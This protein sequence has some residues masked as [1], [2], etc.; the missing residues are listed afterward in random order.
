MSYVL[1]VVLFILSFYLWAGIV[2]LAQAWAG[3]GLMNE[4]G[5]RNSAVILTGSLAIIVA[6][7]SA[8]LAL[9]A[10]PKAAS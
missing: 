8:V 1:S 7:V 4:I 2:F 9:R 10:I 3:W 5:G 6:L